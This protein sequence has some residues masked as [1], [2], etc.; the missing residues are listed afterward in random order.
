MHVKILVLAQQLLTT[1]LGR[2]LATCTGRVNVSF[3]RAGGR[4][5]DS[6]RTGANRPELY[7]DIPNLIFL[8][9]PTDTKR[10]MGQLLA[11]Y[12]SRAQYERLLESARPVHFGTGGLVYSATSPAG[13]LLVVNDGTVRLSRTSTDGRERTLAL[14]EHGEWLGTCIAGTAMDNF[15]ANA[16]EDTHLDFISHQMLDAATRREPRLARTLLQL[17][18]DRFSHL[19]DH[20]QRMT[21]PSVEKRLAYWLIEL[22][23]RYGRATLD[24]RVIVDRHFSQHQLA[25]FVGATRV[26]ITRQL[27]AWKS[28]GLVDVRGRKI[29]LDRTFATAISANEN[30]RQTPPSAAA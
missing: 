13:G 30:R 14:V 5:L 18:S 9:N 2:S 1:E 16:L 20:M 7:T 27:S 21:D 4:L 12:L 26:A 25:E 24:G 17:T 11:N 29:I 22:E 28:V 3:D 6:H 19:L 23:T 15:S 8:A 10:T